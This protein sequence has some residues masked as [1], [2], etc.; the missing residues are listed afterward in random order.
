MAIATTPTQTVADTTTRE[1]FLSQALNE[2]LDEELERDPSMFLAGE[3][4][5]VWG[6]AY[7]V[8]AGLLDKWGSGRVVDTPIA[9]AAIAGLGIG[10]ALTG[11]RPVI[12]FMY[13]D[14]MGIAMD[15]IVNQAA[16][17]RYMF[18]GKARLPITYR[19]PFGAGTGNAAQHTQSLEAWFAH[20]P[21]L[22]VV[23]CSTP[24]DAKG[25]LKSAIREDNVVIMFE[26]KALYAMRGHVPEDDYVIP[27]GLADVKREGSDVSVI[28]YARQVHNAL[29]AAEQLAGE[30]ISVEVIDIRS[31]YPLDIETIIQSVRKTNHAVVVYEAVRFGGFGAEIAAQIQ[32][33]AFDYLD[34]P[35][36]R[37][38]AAYAPTPFSE[39]LEK[40]AFP[41]AER[42]AAE[43]RQSLEGAR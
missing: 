12:E 25:L 11:S 31:L 18:G 43:I 39:P 27:L 33:L 30:G 22:K 40:G 5:G 20:V 28:S 32:E 21:G 3:E 10:A 16:K 1:I 42:V 17:N 26:H 23:T 19:A 8:T 34:A 2:A 7:N 24:Y 13:S 4:I 6:G 35:V 15:Q 36:L 41:D 38:G 37:L 29:E 9:E 14:F